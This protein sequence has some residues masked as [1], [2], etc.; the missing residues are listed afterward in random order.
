MYL[1]DKYIK[2]FCCLFVHSFCRA[3]VVYA[4]LYA[5][6]WEFGAHIRGLKNCLLMYTSATSGTT[7]PGCTMRERSSASTPHREQS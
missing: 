5:F 6:D 2:T 1:N 7:P 4:E 3:P